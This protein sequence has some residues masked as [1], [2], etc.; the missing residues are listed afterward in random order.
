[1]RA[2]ACVH[3]CM[4]ALVRACV[5]ACVCVCVRSCERA[6][7]CVCVRACAGRGPH[8]EGR[9]VVDP[10]RRPVHLC[11]RARASE[12]ACARVCVC[13]LSCLCLF[14]RLAHARTRARAL[15]RASALWW[16]RGKRRPVTASPCAR[17]RSTRAARR[18]QARCIRRAGNALWAGNWQAGKYWWGGLLLLLFK[19]GAFLCARD[20]SVPRD[21]WPAAA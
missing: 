8:K 16:R 4:R 2:C 9:D 5:H 17:P 18:Q 19:L 20:G 3:A 15:T 14:V 11:A 6:R 10:R 12:R 1:M 7:V 21:L 13:V